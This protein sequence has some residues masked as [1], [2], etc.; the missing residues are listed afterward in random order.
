MDVVLL[1]DFEMG[2]YGALTAYCKYS[3]L[4]GIAG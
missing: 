1:P 4:I 2:G 3:K